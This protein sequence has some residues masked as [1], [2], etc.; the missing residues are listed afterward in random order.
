MSKFLLIRIV[1]MLMATLALGSL[2]SCGS[3]G[4]GRNVVIPPFNMYWSM[5]VADL[6]GDGRLDIVAS[7]SKMAGPPPHPGV[8]AIF[9]QD[10]ANPGNFLPL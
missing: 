5:A 3:A 6:S 7:Y 4:N 1:V 2:A 8:V 10:A 9:F